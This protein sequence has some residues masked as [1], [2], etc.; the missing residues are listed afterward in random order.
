VD[1]TVSVKVTAVKDGDLAKSFMDMAG[2]AQKA[3]RQLKNL[4]AEAANGFDGMSRHMRYASQQAL[5]YNQWLAG[6]G[7]GNATSMGI[8]A[9]MSWKQGGQAFGQFFTGLNQTLEVFGK[10]RAAVEMT[11]AVFR[12]LAQETTHAGKFAAGLE[13]LQNRL[14]GNPGGDV[15]LGTARLFSGRDDPQGVYEHGSVLQK[16]FAREQ[17]VKDAQARQDAAIGRGRRYGELDAN[18]AA[19]RQAGAFGDM[20]RIAESGYSLAF[21]RERVADL[22]GARAR[23]QQVGGLGDLEFIRND[24]MRSHIRTPE[25]RAADTAILGEIN[26]NKA[27]LD[28]EQKNLAKAEKSWGN[29]AVQ[30]DEIAEALKRVKAAQEQLLASE[31]KHLDLIRQQSQERLAG[32]AQ[33]RDAT[34][35]II[36]AEKGK[37]QSFQQE[38]GRLNPEERATAMQLA[39]QVA[40]GMPLQESQLEQARKFGFFG[41]HVQKAELQLGEQKGFAELAKLLNLDNRLKQ[42]EQMKVEIQNK[43]ELELKANEEA[44]I[45]QLSKVLEPHVHKMTE[46]VIQLVKSEMDR[47]ARDLRTARDAN[48]SGQN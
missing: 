17:A 46:T 38:F 35:A 39:K 41:E 30:A 10:L 31:Q 22:E 14:L 47:R 5:K 18:L 32:L 48:F 12:G 8:P 3:E 6:R 33:A 25:Q 44:V 24:V 29:P 36:D 40:S 26:R 1:Q 37:L 43:I 20:R 11:A 15:Y 16:A 23:A 27:V 42:A 4:F 2:A 34:Q 28:M 13:G 21:E 9:E 7:S 19:F 45:D